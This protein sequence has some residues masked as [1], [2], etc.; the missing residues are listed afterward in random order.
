VSCEAAGSQLGHR[1]PQR[2]W[3]TSSPKRPAAEDT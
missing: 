2:M 3:V 1:F